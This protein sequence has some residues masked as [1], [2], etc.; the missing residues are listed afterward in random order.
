[1]SKCL[2]REAG[3]PR[4][5]PDA[6]IANW[7]MIDVLKKFGDQRGLTVAQVALAWLLAQK[8]FI[9]PIPGT[10]KLAHLKE[11]LAAADFA[12][13]SVELKSLTDQLSAIEITG[14][15]L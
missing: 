12:F 14:N 11:N 7:K 15:R 2:W 9:V 13:S 1:M 5:Q 6:V 8:P 3:L 10:T 4:Y